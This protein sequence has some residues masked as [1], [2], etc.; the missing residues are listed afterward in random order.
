MSY[1]RTVPGDVSATDRNLWQAIMAEA[2][3]H[4]TYTAYAEK[5]R[6]EGH[7]EVA[8]VFEEVARAETLHGLSYLKVA[9]AVDSTAVNLSR[10]IEGETR[11]YTRT[12]P[13]MINDAVADNRTEAVAAFTDAME[14]E[15]EHQIAFSDALSRLHI[16]H[17]S[18]SFAVLDTPAV[19][20]SQAETGP[21]P[22]GAEQTALPLDL[23][24]Y[25]DAALALDKEPFHVANLG[26]LREVVFGAQDGI[27]ST[28]A[29]TTSI[30]IAVGTTGTV[31]VA[32]LAAAAAGMISMAAGAYLGSRAE[33]DVREAAI[34]RQVKDLEEKPEEQLAEL[35][36]LFQ[37]E[38]NTYDEAVRLANQIAENESLWLSTLLEKK[39]GISPDL[40]GN[41]LKDAAVMCVS[42]GG[43]AIIPIIPFLF[44][45]VGWAA[46]GWSVGLSL[47]GL[48][49]LGLVKGRL[50]Q[51][52]PILQGL[53]ILGIGAVSAALGYGLGEALPRLL[54]F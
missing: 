48:F 5:A 17:D 34:A 49:V 43:A 45:S 7:P 19:P 22:A 26:R 31:L 52:S 39:L 36:I 37:R 16:Q 21:I 20:Y 30:A 28:V 51:K 32:G 27:I 18:G 47:A 25:I 23:E 35:V 54:G 4:L 3:A 42:F 10:V 46:I 12:Y 41:P 11:E 44:L 50:V 15:K 24:N 40:G 1:S 14:Q 6:E 29:L 53:E 9:G 8:E 33:E 38:G 2:I 13:R